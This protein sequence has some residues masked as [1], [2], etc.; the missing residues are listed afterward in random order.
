MGDTVLLSLVKDKLI[1]ANRLGE[2]PDELPKVPLQLDFE[3][4]AKS[5]RLA[6][7]AEKKDYELDLRKE[8]DLN[9][10]KMIHR[11]DI[12]EINWGQKVYARS[13]GTFK[14]AWTL[15]WKPEMYLSL[16]DKAVWGNTLEDACT[17]YLIDTS[18]KSQNIGKIADNIQKA[19]PAELFVAIEFLLKKSTKSLP[20]QPIF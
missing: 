5:N 11:L 10:S 1:V 7:T 9:R 17:K 4:L 2:V 13:K 15:S 3:K 20:F 12:L 14:E 6:L 18:Q 8:L 16:I 19:I